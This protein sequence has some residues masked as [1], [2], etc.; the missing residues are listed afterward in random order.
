M[1]CEEL[2]SIYVHVAVRREVCFFPT[3]DRKVCWSPD[4]LDAAAAGSGRAATGRAA[5][6]YGSPQ[7]PRPRQSR[8]GAG[9]PASVFLCRRNEISAL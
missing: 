7:P 8:A 4:W 5:Q 2:F 1:L 9:G 3:H 6:G